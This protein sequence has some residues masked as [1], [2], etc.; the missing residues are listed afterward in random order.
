MHRD[1]SIG[2]LHLFE[3]R[4]LI[5]DFEFAKRKNT[6]LSHEHAVVSFQPFVVLNYS[7]FIDNYSSHFPKIKLM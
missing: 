7:C 1:C 3:G 5:G 4:G 2:N 6:D